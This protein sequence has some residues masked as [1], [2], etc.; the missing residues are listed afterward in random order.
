MA[1]Q[2]VATGASLPQPTAKETS[3]LVLPISGLLGI[4]GPLVAKIKEGKFIDLG[5]LFLE[6][7]EWAFERST[8]DQKEGS[9]KHFPLTSIADWTLSFTTFIAVVV[10][11]Y[12]HRAVP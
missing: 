5:D 7:L 3:T 12:P 1:T 4:P 8:E 11:F 9:K 6:A 10:H 2:T